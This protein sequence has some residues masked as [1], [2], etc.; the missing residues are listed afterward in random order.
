MKRQRRKDSTMKNTNTKQ[1]RETVFNYLCESLYDFDGTQA[2]CAKRL[3]ERFEREYNYPDSK[4]REPNNQ[5]RVAS[6]LSGLPINIACYYSEIIEVSES[7]HECG[8]T[9]AQKDHVC[10]NWFN[11]LAFKTLQLWDKHGIAL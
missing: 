6:W 10:E 3:R 9:D 8:L 2:D 4:R 11:F 1:F 5:A 7:W